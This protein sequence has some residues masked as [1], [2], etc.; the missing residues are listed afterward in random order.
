MNRFSFIKF[1]RK[2]SIWVLLVIILIYLV[3]YFYKN[4]V[5]EGAVKPP[6]RKARTL[7]PPPTYEYIKKK[8]PDLSEDDKNNLVKLLSNGAELQDHI[9]LVILRFPNLA[10]YNNKL[11]CDYLA[12]K[13]VTPLTKNEVQDIYY[14]EEYFNSAY[15][16][17]EKRKPLITCP[18]R[19]PTKTN[20]NK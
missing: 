5:V 19:P 9:D 1:L 6:P 16:K 14:R 3:I 7:P 20:I 15:Y 12:K 18:P 4:K 8:R 17:K 13:D 10:R 2:N 11:T